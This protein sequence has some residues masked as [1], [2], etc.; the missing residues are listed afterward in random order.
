[1]MERCSPHHLRAT[2][3]ATEPMPGEHPFQVYFTAEGTIPGALLGSDEV[4][5]ADE[6]HRGTEAGR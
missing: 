2:R 4:A 6:L 5:A 1:M 3:I